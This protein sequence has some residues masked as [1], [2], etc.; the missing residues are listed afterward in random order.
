MEASSPK[1]FF[2]PILQDFLSIVAKP[3]TQKF[4]ESNVLQPVL[5]RIFQDL[6]PYILGVMTLW[7]V[8]FLCVALILILLVRGSIL[9]N[10]FVIRK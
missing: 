8:M 5:R 4:I 10:I 1:E 7:V 9:D 6:Y 2:E 3:E